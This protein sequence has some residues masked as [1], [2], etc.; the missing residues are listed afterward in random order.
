[1]RR[2]RRWLSVVGSIC[3][4]SLVGATASVQQT[5]TGKEVRE[6]EIV[7]VDGNKVVV[8]GQKGAQEITVPP[9]FRL[10]V[11]GKPVSVADLK[12]GMKGTA[13]I[14]TTTTVTP[15]HVTE[16]RNAEVMKVLGN[17]I[18]VRG[19]KGM[20]MYSEADAAKR[21]I[22]I[23][24]DGRPVQFTE[25]REGDRL[26]ATIVTSAPPKVMT[27]RQVD[28]AMSS[29]APGAAPPAAGAKPAAPAAPTAGAGAP[30]PAPGATPAT[31][32]RRLPKT[33]SPLPLVGLLGAA[34]LTVG[35]ILAARRR[36]LG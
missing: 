29:A 24:R 3:L 27:Q 5:T 34:S 15:V 6:F 23:I 4:V 12:P 7:S 30:T 17:S 33:A 35:F 19:E 22:R 36:H 25:L 2:V 28:A 21:G 26:T 14:T 16:V 13:T 32:G 1:M 10:T 20:Q 8:K 18:I 31:S 11:D 9:D